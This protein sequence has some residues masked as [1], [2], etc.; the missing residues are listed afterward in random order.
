MEIDFK[1]IETHLN[2]S[3]NS[4]IET[5]VNG[6]CKKCNKPFTVNFYNIFRK[7][8]FSEI[9]HKCKLSKAKAIERWDTI[10]ITNQT[11]I[12][13]VIKRINE[14]KNPTAWKTTCVIFNCIEC[15]KEKSIQLKSFIK[16]KSII[17]PSCKCIRTNQ[18]LYGYKTSFSN[19]NVQ[20]K[21]QKSQID[22]YGGIGLAAQ[23]IKEKARNTNLVKYGAENPLSKGTTAY[24]KRNK[25]VKDVYGVDNVFQNKNVKEQIAK[26]NLEKYGVQ[27]PSSSDDI[28]AKIVKTNLSK[29][30]VESF[31]QTTDFAKYHKSSYV[32]DGIKFDSSWELIFYIYQVDHN[33]K[34]IRN[35]K[36]LEYEYNGKKHF[37]FP[38]FNVNGK[39]YEIKGDHFW[40]EDG[41]MQN[42]FDHSMDGLF[43][44]KHQCGLKNNVTFIRKI[45]IIEMENYIIEKYTNDYLKLF[46][47]NI[48]FPFINSDFT[49]KSDMGVIRHFHKSIYYAT[50]KG[51]IS[52]FDAWKDK[53][54][55]KKAALNRIKYVGRCKPQDIVQGFTIAWIA[56]KIS[57][58]KPTLAKRLIQKYLDDYSEIFDPFSGFSG[59]LIGAQN[60]NKRYIGQDLNIDHVLESNEIIKHKNYSNATCTLQDILTDVPHTYECLFTCPP[61]GGKEH[62]NENNDE[63]EKSCDEW[64]DICLEKYKCKKYLFVVDKTEKYKN[65][66]VEVITNKSHFG[67]NQEFVVLI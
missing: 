48:D 27:N 62:W 14:C 7:K 25:T 5:T 65:N 19:E 60:C 11:D 61:Y 2:D 17:C 4:K 46:K 16:D 30:G 35:D 23:D 26:T 6:V 59:R 10:Q 41:T 67:V 9:C 36:K 40:K 58:F 49:D 44:A 66:I 43:E 3:K 20:I 8:D 63:V 34:I 18:K 57:V 38:D 1:E 12:E 22:K 33:N 39:L 24:I 64:I 55:V 32:Y 45:E 37:Y 28:K 31:T 51:K 52:P 54:L 29:Y 50:K 42:P 56:P 15:G 53:T 21:A 47:E 13:N